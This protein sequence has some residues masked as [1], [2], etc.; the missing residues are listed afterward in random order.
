MVHTIVNCQ[1]TIMLGALPAPGQAPSW[2]L[3]ASPLVTIGEDGSPETEFLRIRG[4][5]R[6]PSGQIVV[7]NAGTSELRVF[8]RAGRYLATAGRNGEG[9]GEFRY[10]ELVG[11]SGDTLL[12]WDGRLR[13]VSRFLATPIP[14]Y[15]SA[16]SVTAT[17]D[18]DRPYVTGRLPTGEWVMS[19]SYSPTFDMPAGA[20]RYATSVGWAAPHGGGRIEWFG[21]FDGYALFVHNPKGDLRTASVGFVAISP[22]TVSTVSGNRVWVLDTDSDSLLAFALGAAQP[23]VF[24]L[25]VQRQPIPDAL[26]RTSLENRLVTRK[27]DRSRAFTRA[28]HSREVLPRRLPV[29]EDLVAGVDGEV[30]LQEFAGVDHLPT[31]YLVVSAAGK[32]VARVQVPAGFR[33][34]EVGRDYLLG[35]HKDEDGVETVRMYGLRRR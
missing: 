24:R 30:W 35:G 17:S 15:L 8:D 6:L 3:T 2:A 18:R 33:V 19:T 7:A 20:H 5:V 16:L 1:L 13:R 26:V 12:A 29:A 28:A 4:V 31:A 14:K 21:S 25:N 11:R 32:I 9:P 27:D 22:T 10:P 34:R 23:A